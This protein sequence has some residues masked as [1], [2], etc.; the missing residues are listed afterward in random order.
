MQQFLTISSAVDNDSCCWTT[1][2]PAKS[3]GDV[4]FCSHLVI[5]HLYSIDRLCINPTINTQV[6]YRFALAQVECTS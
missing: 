1:V 4:M 3:D 2:L 5:R 6:I